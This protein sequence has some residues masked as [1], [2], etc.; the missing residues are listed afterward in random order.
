MQSHL[1]TINGFQGETARILERFAY[2]GKSYYKYSY[3]QDSHGSEGI[4]IL[5]KKYIYPKNIQ[6]EPLST[7]VM[8]DIP[9]LQITWIIYN[10]LGERAN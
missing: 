4:P 9:I 8:M 6:T 3:Y 7:Q 2:W 5:I 10:Y 1:N